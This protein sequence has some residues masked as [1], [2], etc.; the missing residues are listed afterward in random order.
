MGTILLNPRVDS[1]MG[2]PSGAAVKNLPAM[3]ELQETWVRSLGREDPLEKEMAT[4]RSIPTWRI[5]WTEETGGLRSMESQRVRLRTEHENEIQRSHHLSENYQHIHFSLFL[6]STGSSGIFCRDI[7]GPSINGFNLAP[8]KPASCHSLPV[9]TC[10]SFHT[11]FR[12]HPL[13]STLDVLFLY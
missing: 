4:H 1:R 8:W 12:S 9:Y 2:F 13:Q 6:V 10:L 3:Q 7:L 11:S 5:S